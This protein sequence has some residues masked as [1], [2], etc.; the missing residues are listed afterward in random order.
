MRK[1]MKDN[2]DSRAQF[3][4]SF[5]GLENANDHGT[6]KLHEGVVASVVK[7]AACS[8]EG[9]IRLAGSGLA[10]S[11]AD[12]LGTKKKNDSAIKIE[13]EEDK[14]Q[15]GISLI[16]E[17]GKNIPSL[18]LNVQTTV[19]EEVKNITGL[20]VTQIDVVIQGIEDPAENDEAITE[21]TEEK[22]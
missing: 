5:D 12:I 9:I 10:D 15:I 4:M 7:N 18:A 11:I 19:I 14:A 17:Y 1:S 16:V 2:K 3:S 13:L 8:V 6:V 20:N 22:E 21:E